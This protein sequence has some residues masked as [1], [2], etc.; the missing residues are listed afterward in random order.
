[1]NLILNRISILRIL[2]KIYFNFLIK[3][4]I[5]DIGKDEGNLNINLRD[6]NI[7]FDPHP[8]KKGHQKIYETIKRV[9]FN[10]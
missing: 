8:N 5:S 10:K 7:S 9:G 2:K 4:D 3:L 1:M 6:E